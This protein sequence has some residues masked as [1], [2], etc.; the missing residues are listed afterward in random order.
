MDDR[1]M[2][3]GELRD[4]RSHA[5]LDFL[6]IKKKLFV[7]EAVLAD[8]LAR[9]IERRAGYKVQIPFNLNGVDRRFALGPQPQ[10]ITS[11]E[12]RSPAA[13]AVELDLAG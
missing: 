4:P 10:I 5:P 12:Q 1:V 7:H 3:V 6:V 13:A 8:E 2:G 11:G 9:R